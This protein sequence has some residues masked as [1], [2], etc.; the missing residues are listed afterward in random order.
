[1]GRQ[2]LNRDVRRDLCGLFHSNVWP[3][4]GIVGSV[5]TG[6]FGLCAAGRSRI[7]WDQLFVDIHE[8]NELVSIPL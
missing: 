1:M 7:D 3:V 4:G 2:G 5:S 6:F 8:Y